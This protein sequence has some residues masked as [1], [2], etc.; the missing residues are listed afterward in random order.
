ML[1][2]FYA[3]LFDFFSG[4]YVSRHHDML[5]AA[6]HDP[7]AVMALTH[8]EVFVRTPSHVVIEINGEHTRGMTMIDQRNLR[9][10]PDPNC[11]VQTDVDADAGFAVITEAIAHFSF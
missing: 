2:G 8:P 7:C 6:V 11:D 1:A 4:T 3:D 5:G 10:V 9:E